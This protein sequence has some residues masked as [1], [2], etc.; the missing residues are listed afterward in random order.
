M[1]V[2]M[3]VVAGVLV[4]L[5]VAFAMGAV[6]ARADG[7]AVWAAGAES[8]CLWEQAARLV[9]AHVPETWCKN[10]TLCAWAQV[11]R[12]VVSPGARRGAPPAA[13]AYA[14][15]AA[16][17]LGAGA[18][19]LM[20]AAGCAAG[21]LVSL[22]A[23]GAVVGLVAPVGW[24]ALTA[25]RRRREEERRVEAAMPEAFGA[26]AISLGS[27]HSLS[28]AMRFVGSH[29]EEPVRTAF[30]RVAFSMVCGN[31]AAEALDDMLRRFPAPGLELVSLALKVSQ[32][33]GAPLSD[34]LADAAATAGERIE[35]TRRLDV[36]TSQARMSA[37]LVAFMP[38]AMTGLLTLFSQDFR[39]GVGTFTGMLTLVV[40]AALN[41]SAWF[42][43]RK[44]MEVRI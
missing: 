13:A 2:A 8:G 1:E 4:A 25:E 41:L 21:A 42:I 5:A 3:P 14:P 18:L 36:K 30:L 6:G 34:L 19:A 26:L 12:G 11:A 17:R 23:W 29:A 32:R 22:S 38:L 44:I 31:S 16:V 33:T 28:Q 40:A 9:G 43:I 10:A 27:G 20:M 7:G 24:C 35:L 37:R 15:V 39:T